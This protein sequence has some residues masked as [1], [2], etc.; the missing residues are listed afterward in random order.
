[1][2]AVSNIIDA[3][4][5]LMTGKTGATDCKVPSGRF[6]YSDIVVE[7]TGAN[8]ASGRPYPFNVRDPELTDGEYS[9]G[10]VTSGSY[11]RRS[12]TV[13]IA[14]AYGNRPQQQRDLQKIIQDDEELLERVLTW[15]PNI[16]LTDGWTGCEVVSSVTGDAG[17]SESPQMRIL[18]LE[19]EVSH[20]E[21]RLD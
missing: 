4:V 20:R 13:E 15:E 12:H 7:A 14:V 3:I 2:S 17:E 18:Y 10:D 21:R 9:P 6:R 19:L 11:M 16:A 1:M 5:D 8:A